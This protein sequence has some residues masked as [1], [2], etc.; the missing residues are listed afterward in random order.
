MNP[1][2]AWHDVPSSRRKGI[3]LCY[4]FEEKRLA[5]WPTPWL[6]Q[7]KLDG[8]RCRVMWDKDGNVLL[9]S[10]ENNPI[11][12]VPHIIEE[13]EAWNLRDVELDGELYHHGMPFEQIHSI[14]G[15]TVNLHPEHTLMELHIFDA[16]SPDPQFKRL[17]AI[18][19]LRHL[20]HLDDISTIQIVPFDFARTI[21]DVMEIHQ[22]YIAD[23]YE[24]MIVRHP[25]SPYV[26]KRSTQIMKFKPKK[27]DVY[28]IIGWKE[29]ISINGNPKGRLGAL[30]CES[31]N[32][33]FAVGTG[34]TDE[35]R[36][37]LWEH[38]H[39]LPGHL[40][41]VAYQHITTGKNVPR[42]PVLMDVI[43]TDMTSL[44]SEEKK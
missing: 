9:V 13:L 29:E 10:S 5:K 43:R 42:F 6:I 8:E 44:L 30:V 31:D 23:D 25:T 39:I 18:N 27:T 40:A 15:R 20:H 16:V 17:D 3:M 28:H 36:E 38:R 19:D 2:V 41:C 24:G 14:V 11:H 22:S 33:E 35:V 4:P 34:M 32:E 7:P 26:R 37:A 1:D 21:K 12:S